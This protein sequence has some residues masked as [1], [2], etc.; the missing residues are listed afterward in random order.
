MFILVISPFYYVRYG[1]RYPKTILGRCIAILWFLTG[2][3]LSSLLISSITSSM[4]VRILDRHLNVARGKKVSI[5]SHLFY[6]FLSP[7]KHNLLPRAFVR[8]DQQSGWEDLNSPFLW[9]MKTKKQIL[10]LV[11]AEMRHWWTPLGEDQTMELFSAV[12]F[13][14][15]DYCSGL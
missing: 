6:D 1:D 13:V 4:S 12:T 11:V 3:V 5:F 10:E 8:L 14:S 7:S 9:R 2:I 15:V